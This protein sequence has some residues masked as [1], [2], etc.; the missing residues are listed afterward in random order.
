MQWVKKGKRDVIGLD[1]YSYTC[2][3]FFSS[4]INPQYHARDDFILLAFYYVNFKNKFGFFGGRC[5]DGPVQTVRSSRFY[6]CT[7]W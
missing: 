2:H 5:P 1:E 4:L 6:P 7:F 3:V